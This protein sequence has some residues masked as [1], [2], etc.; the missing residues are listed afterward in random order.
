[1]TVAWGFT[2]HPPP[3]DE[4]LHEKFLKHLVQG[5]LP[6]K[7]C[8]C[9][10]ATQLWGTT[11]SARRRKTRNGPSCL[12]KIQDHREKVRPMPRKIGIRLVLFIP[13]E[14]FHREFFCFWYNKNVVG[15]EAG[16]NRPRCGK[17]C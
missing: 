7:D 1:M 9:Y 10:A 14:A 17:S 16:C 13:L 6:T 8:I 15:V 3:Q 12:G 2:N 11:L 5:D 4:P